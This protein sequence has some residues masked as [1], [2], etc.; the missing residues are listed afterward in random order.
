MGEATR[1]DTK[2]V[3]PPTT[4]ADRRLANVSVG[5]RRWPK[6]DAVPMQESNKHH[7]IG[8]SRAEERRGEE[9]AELSRATQRNAV[10]WMQL[11]GTPSVRNAARSGN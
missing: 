1:L 5:R 3:T 11:R 7:T 2:A 9:R 6:I 4:E 8:Q 10:H